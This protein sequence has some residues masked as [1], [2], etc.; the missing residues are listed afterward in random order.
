MPRFEYEMS[1]PNNETKVVKGNSIKELS[2]ASGYT[3]DV[4][5][6]KLTKDCKKTNIIYVK[7][8]LTDNAVN[9]EA[10]R[11]TTEKKVKDKNE[12]KI[13]NNQKYKYEVTVSDK[14]IVCRKLKEGAELLNIH[15]SFMYKILHNPKLQEEYKVELL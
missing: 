5:Y 3:V 12:P 1:Y 2:E 8:V 7:R 13:R 14:K 6:N 10:I 11:K 4:I 9:R 15:T